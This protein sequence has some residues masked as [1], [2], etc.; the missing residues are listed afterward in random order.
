MYDDKLLY[1]IRCAT[2]DN[3]EIISKITYIDFRIAVSTKE[4]DTAALR[5][6]QN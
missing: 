4:V 1:V 6:V 2:R 5:S 3:A